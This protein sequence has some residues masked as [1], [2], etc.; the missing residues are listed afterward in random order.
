VS[1]ERRQSLIDPR[2]HPEHAICPECAAIGFFDQKRYYR[3]PRT[4][5]WLDMGTRYEDE[6]AEIQAALRHLV[7]NSPQVKA[8]LDFLVG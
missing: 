5:E 4:Q 2:G 6:L 8:C 7:G 1:G 3:L